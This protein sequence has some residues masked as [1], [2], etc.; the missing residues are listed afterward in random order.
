MLSI[1]LIYAFLSP[2]MFNSKEKVTLFS[3]DLLGC[4]YISILF[5]LEEVVHTSEYV[6][7]ASDKPNQLCHTSNF[8][9]VKNTDVHLVVSGKA[10][11]LIKAGVS[12]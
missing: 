7:I 4:F 9:W 2:R 10:V 12:V 11:V 1:Y 5:S 8:Q 6:Y 3:Q